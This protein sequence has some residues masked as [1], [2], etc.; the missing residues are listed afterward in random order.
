MKPQ[1]QLEIRA[2]RIDLIEQHKEFLV[3]AIAYH[4]NGCYPGFLTK[5]QRST[6][7]NVSQI[8]VYFLY[9][10]STVTGQGK[11]R[12][13][14]LSGHPAYFVRVLVLRPC[15]KLP[16]VYFTSLIA[17]QFYVRI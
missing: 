1:T 7:W 6:P 10:N 9:S 8:Q 11:T 12:V 15:S 4:T 17:N 3:R 14:A 16:D 5:D 13:S 2:L